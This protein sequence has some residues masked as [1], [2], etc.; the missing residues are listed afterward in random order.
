MTLT[1]GDGM[2][3]EFPLPCKPLT[4]NERLHWSQKAV[5]SR[6]WRHAAFYAAAALGSPSERAMPASTVSVVIPVRGRRARDPHNWYPTVKAVVDGLVDA[7]VWPDDN[8]DWV[9]TLEPVLRVGA[10][11][12]VV[13]IE[14]RVS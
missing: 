1:V 3:V 11:N 4:M 2:R 8:S 6:V 12:V 13:D 9:T 5:R 14:P 10:G 7:G